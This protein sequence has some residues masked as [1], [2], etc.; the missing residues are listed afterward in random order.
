M[1]AEITKQACVA[2]LGNR[3]TGVIGDIDSQLF[4]KWLEIKVSKF[5][6][7]SDRIHKTRIMA[8]LC[9]QERICHYLV[10]W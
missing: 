3:I 8:I 9:N 2:T 7:M 5:I 4:E 6:P 1:F 10:W